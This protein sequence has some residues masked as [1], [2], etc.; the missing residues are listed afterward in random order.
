M[1]EETRGFATYAWSHIYTYIIYV[2]K[3]NATRMGF[4][5]PSYANGE[6]Y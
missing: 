2:G 3:E 1:S 4:S 5:L 6:S